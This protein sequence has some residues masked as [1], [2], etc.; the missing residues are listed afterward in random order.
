[1]EAS[2]VRNTLLDFFDDVFS[3]PAEFL[4]HDTGYRSRS[5]SYEQVK[6]AAIAFAGRLRTSG[7]RKGDKIIFWG[8]NR[9]EWIIGLWGCLLEGVIVVPVDYRASADLMNR[10]QRIVESRVVL[11]GDDV[12]PNETGGGPSIWR[13]AE[14]EWPATASMPDRPQVNPDDTA[15]IIFTSGATADPKGVVITHRNILANIVPIERE[16]AKY[17]LYARPFLPIRFLNLL[18]LSHMFGQA[19]TTYVPPMLPGVV[20]FMRGFNPGEIVRQIHTRRISVLV[21]VPKILDVLRGYMLQQVPATR[22]ATESPASASAKAPARPRRSSKSEGGSARHILSRLWRYREVHRVLGWKFWAFVVGAAPLER[23]LEE[24]WSRLGFAVVQGYGLTETAPI[25]TLN[26]PFRPVRGTVGKPIAGVDVKIAPD[27]EILVRGANVTPGYYQ[28]EAQDAEAFKEGWFHT[29]DMGEMDESG[30]LVVR[31]RKKEM[32][33]TPEGLH[34][35]PEDVERVLD[36]L[37]GVRESAVVGL[38][39]DG[40][41]RVH[42][43]LAL[44]PGVSQ[45]EVIRQANAKLEEHQKIRSASVW[46]RDGL[47]RTE[48]TRKLRRR[49][50]KR[51]TESGA[52]PERRE[53]TAAAASAA[54]IVGQLARRE[55]V[56]A[57]TTLDELGL[58]SLERVELMTALE[59]RLDTTIDEAAFSNARTVGDLEALVRQP[60]SEEGPTLGRAQPP[61]RRAEPPDRMMFPTWNRRRPARAVRAVALS[62]WLL[63]LARFF[64]RIQVH[65]MEHLQSAKGPVIFAA[66]H[67]SHMDTPVILAALPA[68][69]RSRVAPAMAKD[70]F[71][72]HFHPERHTTPQ[73]LTNRVAYYLAALLFNAFPLPRREAGTRDTLRYIGDLVSAGISILIFPEGHLT[74][75]GEIK[76]FQPGIGMMAARL[77][78]PVVPVRLEGLERVLHRS[79]RMARPGR[80]DV[81]F[82]PPLTLKGEDYVVLA[83]QVE[84]AVRSLQPSRPTRESD[85]GAP[86]VKTDPHRR[87]AGWMLVALGLVTSVTVAVAVLGKSPS[88]HH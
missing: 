40:Q 24:F 32:I 82:G 58:S 53:P 55:N 27:G 39:R 47:P 6:R 69:W 84:D 83:R 77:D 64:A 15:E 74:E 46:T 8:E 51:W 62:V 60:S 14:I 63:P 49:E 34:V 41:E 72:P 42:A 3:S 87:V 78:L 81:T 28:A 20:V 22:E 23:D 45:A 13:M 37:P 73:V 67:Q 12:H 59:E 50:L 35:F 9:A 57:E 43:V 5:Y 36:D 80:V 30:R 33:V 68:A 86:P 56:T 38:A 70:F 16:V 66:N 48:G 52:A 17:R 26:S 1:M 85:R 29:G 31:G 88:R 44:E 65:G 19:M 11:I 21:C 71:E 2:A 4:V 79:S 25:V 18:P 54:S 10:I 76:R 75:R 61:V 7:I